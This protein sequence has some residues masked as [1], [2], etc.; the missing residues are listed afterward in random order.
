MNPQPTG[1]I[2]GNDLILKRSF[3]AP[4][5]DVWTSITDSDSTV[6]W[7]GRWEG[8][9]GVGNTIR[10][11]MVFEKGDAWSEAHIDACE[12]PRHLALTTAGDYGV[13][14]EVSLAQQGDTTELT[15]VHHLKD[16]KMVGDWGP[17]WE[18]YLDNLVAA[19]AN[20][21]L[22]TFDDYYPSQKQY[23]IDQG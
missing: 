22:P 17:G 4:I 18:Y 3:K 6:R 13:C 1:R 5:E 20:A 12:R 23:F 10:I 16:K 11:L 8:T 14:I 21:T 15:F 7:F 9:P 2:Q 19:R